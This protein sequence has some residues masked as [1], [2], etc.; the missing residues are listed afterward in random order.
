M[1]FKLLIRS[2]FA[3]VLCRCELKLWGNYTGCISKVSTLLLKNT[4]LCD[5]FFMQ[6]I[7]TLFILALETCLASY[8]CYSSTLFFGLATSIYLIELSVESTEFSLEWLTETEGDFDPVEGGLKKESGNF[9]SLRGIWL[10]LLAELGWRTESNKA[11][12][13]ESESPRMWITW[14]P[15]CGR[16]PPGPLLLPLAAIFIL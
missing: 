15:L 7:V 4:T 6:N 9:L 10:A 3:F 11:C 1:E 2:S 13:S 8:I 12:S 14:L 5:K 16:P